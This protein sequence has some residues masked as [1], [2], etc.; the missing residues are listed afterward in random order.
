MAELVL[1]F[2][3]AETIHLDLACVGDT[4]ADGFRRF[5]DNGIEGQV[6]EID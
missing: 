2:S 1:S 3:A 4:L 5:A 6:F